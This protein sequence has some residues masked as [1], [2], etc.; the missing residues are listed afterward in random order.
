M[1][2]KRI[3]AI[4]P[5]YTGGPFRR[6]D[7]LYTTSHNTVLRDGV[8]VFTAASPVLFDC[9]GGLVVATQNTVSYE[10]RRFAFGSVVT[11]LQA[12]SSCIVAG[13]RS[14]V[15]VLD[16]QL[17]E[18]AR[19]HVR[20]CAS[21]QTDS[22]V[23]VGTE[24]GELHFLRQGLVKQHG[25]ARITGLVYRGCLY[26]SSFD[27]SVAIWRRTPVFVRSSAIDTVLG[28]DVFGGAVLALGSRV[29]CRVEDDALACVGLELLDSAPPFQPQISFRAIRDGIVATT[30]DELY[31]MRT[32]TLLVGNNDE[33][34][35][36]RM[37]DGLVVCT[38]SGRLRVYGQRLQM[39]QAH[40][41]AILCYSPR[42][43]ASCSRE[44]VVFYDG[45]TPLGRLLLGG[46]CVDGD[47]VLYVASGCFVHC[48]D[49]RGAGLFGQNCSHVCAMREGERS[50]A[51]FAWHAHEKEV[52]AVAVSDTYVA[53][54]SAD[55]T[56]RL[57]S[58]DAVLLGTGS[59][60]RGVSCLLLEE[61]RLVSADRCIKT[62]AL[63]SM[64]LL[65]TIEHDAPVLCL[66]AR[67][68]VLFAGD[69]LG[70]VRAYKA[71]KVVF[72]TVAHSD[73]VW[74]VA[75][76]TVPG[77]LLQDILAGAFCAVPEVPG[78]PVELLATGGADGT[79]NFYVENTEEHMCKLRAAEEE[80]RR[81]EHELSL[82]FSARSL[83]PLVAALLEKGDKRADMYVRM[84]FY[85]E[86]A[87]SWAF[88]QEL[89]REKLSASV[90][91]LGR[92][93]KN[94]ELCQRLTD[95]CGLRDHVEREMLRRHTAAVD[96]M[97]REMLALRLFFGDAHSRRL[98]RLDAAK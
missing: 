97:Y 47:A 27:G 35:D 88:F 94:A 61:E 73:R 59:H 80:R 40:A 53:T 85:S 62:W 22:T 74:V 9:L 2:F 13:T 29:L 26:S 91:R 87:D 77:T 49:V 93:I 3:S 34:T 95:V 5:L 56:V 11:Y 79:I 63:P 83:R 68:G 1:N 25:S 46:S 14:E 20:A 54:A 90:R 69:A 50:A 38:N 33:V 31:D 10:G 23:V 48:V 8:V 30:E 92:R 44:S 78:G 37:H 19:K 64:E 4:G 24:R 89:D 52:T 65:G 15:C 72:Q 36:L 41:D 75:P 18:T 51:C 42:A 12:H 60:R 6:T 70:V 7:G 32:G 17:C 76:C 58:R 39:V 16:A 55:R 98:Q 43:R 81:A 66:G 96:G 82:L 86:G 57:W 21:V 84:L 71:G 45:H 67:G 28:L